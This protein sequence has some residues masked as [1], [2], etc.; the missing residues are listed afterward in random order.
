MNVIISTGRVKSLR[1]RIGSRARIYDVSDY[2]YRTS[3]A[4]ARVRNDVARRVI[5]QANTP[6]NIILYFMHTQVPTPDT[7][8]VSCKSVQVNGIYRL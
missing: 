2:V 6:H 7:R 3:R 5:M 1:V 8:R 4:R